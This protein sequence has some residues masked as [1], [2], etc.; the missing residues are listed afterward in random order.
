MPTVSKIKKQRPPL[1][2]GHRHSPKVSSCHK[3]SIHGSSMQHSY[4]VFFSSNGHML[5]CFKVYL[6]CMIKHPVSADRILLIL[7]ITFS[8][9]GY[10]IGGNSLMFMFSFHNLDGSLSFLLVVSFGLLLIVQSGS[11]YPDIRCSQFSVCGS[12]IDTT[13]DI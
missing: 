5:F 12:R 2:C 3:V 9:K 6:H 8:E 1:Q 13:Y 4:T 10:R 11:E 7:G